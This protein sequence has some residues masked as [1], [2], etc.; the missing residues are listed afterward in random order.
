MALL[1][2]LLVV[3]IVAFLD[4]VKTLVVDYYTSK[5]RTWAEIPA[6]W[7]DASFPSWNEILFVLGLFLAGVHG[8]FTA[9]L[10]IIL[11]A[12]GLEFILYWWTRPLV[13]SS[14][15]PH[16]LKWRCPVR[17][18]WLHLSLLPWWRKEGVP[19]WGAYLFSAASIIVSVLL[20]RIG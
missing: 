4:H 17:A 9:A 20:W 19:W 18:P 10:F 1:Y 12:G 7:K 11:V 15:S 3:L 5:G 13:V 14:P 6:F 16:E 8:P 2:A